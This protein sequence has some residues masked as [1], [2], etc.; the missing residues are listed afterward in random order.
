[1]QLTLRLA[2]SLL[3]FGATCAGQ[4][5]A[6]AAAKP[7]GP[8]GSLKSILANARARVEQ[9][10][11]RATGRLVQVAANGARTNNPLALASHSFPD[12]LRTMITVTTPDHTR[13]RYLLTQDQTGHATIEARHQIDKAPVKL[14]PD[15]WGE[16]VAGTLFYPEDFASGQFFWAKQTVLPPAKY[17]AR[18]CFVLKSEPDPGQPTQYASVTSWLDQKSGAPVYVEAVPKNGSPTK[19]FV[20]Y[21]LEQIGGLWLSRQVEAKLAGKPGS[22]ILLIDHGSPHAHLTRKDFNLTAPAGSDAAP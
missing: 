16:G 5:T 13:V 21:D 8:A 6:Q 22:T 4:T 11:V 2:A 12:G 10:D 19:Q 15:H 9:S 3:A 1:M 18:D 20:F 7:A 14:A 17:G